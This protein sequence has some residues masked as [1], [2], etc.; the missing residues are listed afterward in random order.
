MES[1]WFQ[2]ILYVRLFFNPLYRGKGLKIRI[3]WQI[4]HWTIELLINKVNGGKNSANQLVAQ[5][6]D[7]KDYKKPYEFGYVDT[8]SVGR[9][10]GQLD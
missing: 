9:V 5:M 7:Y 10:K 4:C 2:V 8:Y 6:L 1:I 3:F